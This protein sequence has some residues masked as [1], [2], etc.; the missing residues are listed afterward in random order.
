MDSYI[1]VLHYPK[2]YLV[3]L[4]DEE[5][6]SFD[7]NSKDQVASFIQEAIEEMYGIKKVQSDRVEIF[8]TGLIIEGMLEDNFGGNSDGQPYRDFVMDYVLK[9]FLKSRDRHEL[10]VAALRKHGLI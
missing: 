1:P 10:M 5:Q 8:K 2:N 3:N 7:I 4:T 9:N 6:S